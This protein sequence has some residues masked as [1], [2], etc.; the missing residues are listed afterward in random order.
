KIVFVLT[1][2]GRAMRQ[3]TRL[4]RLI[5][6]PDHYYYIH[7]DKRQEF[8]FRELLPLQHRLANVFLTNQRFS[9]IWGGASLLQAHLSFLRELFEDKPDWKWDYYINLSESDYPVKPISDLVEYLTAY[10]GLNFLRSFGKNVPRFI[11]KQGM[12][13]T[14]HECED[15]L[16]RV[17][18]RTLPAG[19]IFDGGSDWIGLFREFARYA[20]T[21]KDKLVTGLKQYYK[22]SLL[23]V[24]SFFHMVLQ[25]SMFCTQSVDN[26]L[27]LTNWRRKQGC[28]CQYKHIVD[29]CGCS[30]NNIK[31]TDM[32]RLLHYDKKPMFFARKFE[33]IVDQ[34]IINSVDLT[35]HGHLYPG[36][37]SLS[38]YWQN[39]YHHLDKATKVKDAALTIYAS[40]ERLASAQLAQSASTCN[41]KPIKLLEGNIYN[42]G[43]HLH[44][45]LVLFAAQVTDTSRV[46]T[47]EAYAEPKYHYGVID[48]KGKAARLL[49]L[50]VG[51]DFDVKELLFRNYG[52]LMGP[53]DEITLRHTWGPGTEFTVSVAWVDPT[54]DIAASYDVHIPSTYHVG[55]Q[56]PLLNR[57]LRPGVWKACVMIDLK[58]VA[59]TQFLVTP[60]T[61]YNNKPIS[62]SELYRTHQGPLGLYTSTDFSEFKTNLHIVED[63]KL[64]QEYA[65]NSKKTGT[66]L[67]QWVDSLTNFFWVVQ[68]SCFIEAFEGCPSTSL[69][70]SATWSSRY[71]DP[72]SD[73]RYIGEKIPVVS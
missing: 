15:H 26:N 27:H 31:I 68:S 20:L 14:F 37:Q 32:E 16:W 42:E 53:Y 25:N 10:K 8:L 13:Q 47:V 63:G 58:L 48:N 73:P 7:V 35:F 70:K 71:A 2:N 65:I 38:S 54:N 5:Y 51:T 46:V 33:A 30:P 64:S 9:T 28:K 55:N 36:I 56:K 44:G 69:C 21:S 17:S 11:K 40:I 52:N 23:P 19:V 67:D 61:F 4:L 1:V 59:Q 60:L 29:W 3:V 12:D 39:V 66:D 22:Y 45:L 41:L 6:S 49:S 62:V 18:P 57:P 34:E 50:E 72:K 43:D 24:E